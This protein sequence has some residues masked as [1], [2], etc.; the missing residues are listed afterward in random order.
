MSNPVQDQYGSAVHHLHQQASGLPSTGLDVWSLVAL[1]VLFI[2][3]GTITLLL[4][5]RGV[6]S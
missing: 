5:F 6:R 1:A 3:I 4:L 2:V